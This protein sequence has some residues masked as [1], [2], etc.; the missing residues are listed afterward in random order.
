VKIVESL[1]KGKAYI[2]LRI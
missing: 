1:K 2:F